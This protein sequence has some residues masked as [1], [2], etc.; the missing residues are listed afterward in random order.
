MF[1]RPKTEKGCTGLS[2]PLPISSDSSLTT[3]KL[4]ARSSI[5]ISMSSKDQSCGRYGCY[6]RGVSA[7]QFADSI[8][9]V[10]SSREYI[11]LAGPSS[12]L[13]SS[14]GG[15]VAIIGSTSGF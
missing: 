9:R 12:R 8:P 5:A 10:A 14:L 6:P 2:L 3:A 11:S 13:R 1:T 4:R 15:S 7:V